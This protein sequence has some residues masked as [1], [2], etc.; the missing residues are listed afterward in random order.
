MMKRKKHRPAINTNLLLIYFGQFTEKLMAC[1][2][3]THLPA[4]T[5]KTK[6]KKKLAGEN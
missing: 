1:V 4:P 2:H 3:R 5:M 6:N